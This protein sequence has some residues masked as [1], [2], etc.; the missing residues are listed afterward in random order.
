MDYIFYE[1]YYLSR[2]KLKEVFSRILTE[3]EWAQ[4][5][6]RK[7]PS[8]FFQILLRDLIWGTPFFF[9]LHIELSQQTICLGGVEEQFFSGW[10]SWK[11]PRG[12]LGKFLG[13][14]WKFPGGIFKTNKSVEEQKNPGEI[15]K[16]FRGEFW[17]IWSY[18]PGSFW[19]S[20][21]SGGNLEKVPGGIL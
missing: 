16:K 13:N 5:G 10:N 9:N 12:I 8:G 3:E 6:S 18:S 20:T 14:S 11:I 19:S 7:P 4:I 21:L 15:L 1:I 2:K 17:K